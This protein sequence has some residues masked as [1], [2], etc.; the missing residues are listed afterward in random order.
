M[1]GAQRQA[2]P[3][4]TKKSAVDV[5]AAAIV[6]TGLVLGFVFAVSLIVLVLLGIAKLIGG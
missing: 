4:S 5:V 6:G 2:G 1:T 3:Y